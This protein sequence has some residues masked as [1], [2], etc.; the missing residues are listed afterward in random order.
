MA[1]SLDTFGT[2]GPRM[3][4]PSC[5]L[6]CYQEADMDRIDSQ[7]R[8]PWVNSMTQVRWAACWRVKQHLHLLDKS[9]SPVNGFVSTL[10]SSPL[11]RALSLWYKYAHCDRPAMAV[12]RILPRSWRDV[13]SSG[14]GL[15]LALL[16][17][18][19]GK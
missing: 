7:R 19:A 18:I 6:S 9:Q 15:Y 14:G 8:Y 13:M 11:L 2:F 16:A 5:Y 10:C 1:L 4:Q 12:V 3:L 17:R